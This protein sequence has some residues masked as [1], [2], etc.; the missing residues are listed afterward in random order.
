MGWGGGVGGGE[1][2][3][4]SA[5]CNGGEGG[6]GGRA[7]CS[8]QSAN[9]HFKRFLLHYNAVGSKPGHDWGRTM[10]MQ[11]HGKIKSNDVCEGATERERERERERGGGGGGAGAG[12]G[13]GGM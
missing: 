8:R 10:L 3:T 4:R 12:G 11:E 6:G 7:F 1:N 5:G 2:G 13:G 9:Q